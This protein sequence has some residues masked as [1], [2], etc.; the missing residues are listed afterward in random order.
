MARS[1]PILLV[2][3]SLTLWAP[4]GFSQSVQPMISFNG[5]AHASVPINSLMELRITGTPNTQFFSFF[6]INSGP[7][8]ILGMNVP[9]SFDQNLLIGHLGAIF[10]LNGEVIVPIPIAATPAI[11]G[12]KFFG[13]VLTF[14]AGLPNGIGLSNG[15]DVTFTRAPSAGADSAGLLGDE[16]TLDGSGNLTPGPLPTGFA[17]SWSILNG[18]AGHSASL[19]GA[20]TAFP[21]LDADVAG[22]YEVEVSILAPGTTGG[23]TDT[24]MFDIH[25]LDIS[26]H[27]Q[28]EFSTADPLNVQATLNGPGAAG[29]EAVG[30]AA[31]MGN[32]VMTSVAASDPLTQ[33]LFK[34]V[35]SNNQILGRGLTVLNN[36]GEALG[37]PSM[38]SL[39]A[40]LRQP[41]LDDLEVALETAFAGVNLSGP[42]AGIPPIPVANVP[43]PFGI[44]LFSA[45]ITPTAF[46]YDPAV[47]IELSLVAGALHMTLTLNNI[48]LT[49]DIDGLLFSAPYNDTGN[50]AITSTVV[51]F[52]VVTT[53]MGGT[54]TTTTANETAALTG[55]SLTFVAG[56]IPSNFATTLLTSVEPVIETTVATTIAGAIPAVVDGALNVLPQQVDLSTSGIDV[57]LDLIPGGVDF[58]AGGL[59]LRFDAGAQSITTSPAAAPLLGYFSTPSP[60]PAFGPSVPGTMTPYGLALSLSD[61]FINQILAAAM[62]AGALELALNGTIDVQGIPVVTE[63]GSFDLIFPNLGFDLFDPTAAVTLAVHPT[64]AP[65]VT[66][67]G[68]GPDH[69]TLHLSDLIIDVRVEAAPGH[70]VSVVRFGVNGDSGLNIGID[71]MLNTLNVT[72]GQVTADAYAVST[73]PGRDATPILTGLTQL[74]PAVIPGLLTGLSGIPIPDPGLGTIPVVVGIVPDGPAGDWISLYLD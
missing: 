32:Q 59:T 27:Q 57:L 7:T 23:S 60:V 11:E 20:D 47:D 36:V 39:V 70:V 48:L 64:V 44:T 61:D 35:A 2:V 65:V 74:L 50:L 24:A 10:P 6:N 63:A 43:G 54:Y 26:S 45:D 41:V 28:G 71:P 1:L 19:N 42:L 55:T 49:F 37:T 66:I 38:D 13:F 4:T 8:E 46:S 73:L 40:E 16:V 21:E 22:S 62:E 56:V 29:F 25:E 69:L 18:P 31:A 58:S 51:D 14:D 34:V 5:E 72:A 9:M 52:D 53:V 12:I 15:A 30:L 68:G 67:G 33:V 17:L 3:C